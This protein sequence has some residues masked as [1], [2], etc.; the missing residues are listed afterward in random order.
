MVC[1]VLIILSKQHPNKVCYLAC[2]KT[3]KLATSFA[4]DCP[5]LRSG[6][7][8]DGTWFLVPGASKD[9]P[10]YGTF[11]GTGVPKKQGS[12]KKRFWL[13]EYIKYSNTQ[14]DLLQIRNHVIWVSK[15]PINPIP[16]KLDTHKR[17]PGFILDLFVLGAPI[18][19]VIVLGRWD[20]LSLSCAEFTTGY[21]LVN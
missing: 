14:I 2:G 15:P 5:K 3:S 6:S 21:P 10:Q 13:A 20:S 8:Y 12:T 4:C 16:P 17:P 9:P 1:S 19:V 11:R 18:S 7:S